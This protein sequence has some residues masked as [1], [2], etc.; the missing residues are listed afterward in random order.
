MKCLLWV[1]MSRGSFLNIS[2][3]LLFAILE[4]KCTSE[5]SYDNH[6]TLESWIISAVSENSQHLNASFNQPLTIT[7][8]NLE[9]YHKLTRM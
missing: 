5:S 9:H 4:E 7:L 1:N 6:I 8:L 3:Q 2:V